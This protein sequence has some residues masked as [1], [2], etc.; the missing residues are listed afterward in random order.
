MHVRETYAESLFQG[1]P[2]G[3][4]LDYLVGGYIRGARDVMTTLPRPSLPKL[5]VLLLSVAV[6]LSAVAALEGSMT[7][8]V[9]AAWFSIAVGI[10]VLVGDALLMWRGSG[11][12][13]RLIINFGVVYWFWL[14]VLQYTLEDPPFPTPDDVY[15]GFFITVP[16]DV[17]VISLIGVNL[18]A[19]TVNLGWSLLPQPERLLGRLADRLDPPGSNLIDLVSLGLVL[20][21]WLQ[22]I[23][24][25]QGDVFSA[26][27]DLLLMRA[28]G[29]SGPSTDVGLMQYLHLLGIFGAALALARI[30]LRTRG[31]KWAR[32]LAVA[33]MF[34]LLFFGQASRFNF[35]YMLLPTIMILLAPTK[36]RIK[37]SQRRLPLVLIMA[38]GTILIMYQGIIRTVGFSEARKSETELTSGFFGHDHF[39]PMMIAVDFAQKQGFY[40][41]PMAPFFVTY[42]IPRVIWPDKPIPQSWV[43]YNA[44]W[45]QGRGLNVTPS[46][47]GQYYLNWGLAGIVYIG[48]FMG[49]LARFCESWFARLDMHRQLMSATVAG[50]LL[51]FLFLSFRTFYPLYFAYPLFGYLIY[52][53]MTR[54]R[55]RQVSVSSCTSPPR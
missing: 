30:A 48:L 10:C 36:H 34:P 16:P 14:G 45:T 37:W 24:S 43:D 5:Y 40:M 22:L 12:V 52:L 8:I 53:V 51:G 29:K 20:L 11:F 35:G 41:E 17:V 32:N 18:F 7:T 25:Y 9:P 50:L 28:G 19:L 3:I 42:F 27:I 39:G 26:I 21:A 49:W 23:I 46:I 47:T 1:A 31:L 44:E 6:A 55:P 38:I 54:R 13:G 15:P 4:N 2:K 33:L